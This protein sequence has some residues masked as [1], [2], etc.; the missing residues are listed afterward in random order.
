MEG[1]AAEAPL[2]LVAVVDQVK[3]SCASPLW[4]LVLCF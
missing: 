1:L 4:D 2:Q 3:P